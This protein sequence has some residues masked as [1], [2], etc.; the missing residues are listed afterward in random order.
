MIDEIVAALTYVHEN[1]LY[2]L[3]ALL[4]S[5]KGMIGT[6]WILNRPSY[7]PGYY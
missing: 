4:M 5:S 6:W 3:I 7:F 1:L 2:I